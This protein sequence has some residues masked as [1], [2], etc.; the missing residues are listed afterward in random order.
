MCSVRSVTYVSSR[1][2]KNFNFSVEQSK[3]VTA[4][5]QPLEELLAVGNP[6]VL[7]LN[8]MLE[9]PAAFALFGIEPVDLA[10]FVRKR[11][12][13]ISHGQGLHRC[14]AGFIRKAP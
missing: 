10:A 8:G 11:L 1:S 9:E 7:Y 2:Q 14:G 4:D 13:Q 5:W 6:D 12:L 3:P